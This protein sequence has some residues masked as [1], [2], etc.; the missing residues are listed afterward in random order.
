MSKFQGL[1][2]Y[3]S[4][5][6]AYELLPFRFERL[7]GGE[8]VLTN[9]VGEFA[10]LPQE[11][12]QALVDHQLPPTDSDYAMLRMK[13]ILREPGDEAT[14][15]LLA[16]KTRTRLSHL[17]N[18]TNLHLFVVS[19]RCDHSCQYCQVSRQSEDKAAFD[20]TRE[21]ADKS[22][23]I[24]FRS[25]N[26]AIKIEFQGGEPL[27]NFPLIQYVVEKAEQRNVA[28]Q[29]NLQFVITTTLS[30]ATDDILGY[31]RDHSIIL[32]SS[33]DGPE[34]LHNKN[35][36]RP[37]RDS[38]ARFVDGLN[39]A[40]DIVGYDAVS[41][42][43]T[44]S[45]ASIARVKDIIDEY[46]RLGF[47]GIFLRH[48]SPYGFA[49]K[50][51]SYQAYNTEQWLKF[52][53]EGLDYIIELNKAGIP[54]I[55][56]YSNILLTKML[57]STDPGFVDL[58]NP[59]GAGITAVVFNYDGEVYASDESRMLKEMGDA[60]FRLGNVHENSYEE[61]FTAEGLLTALEESFTLSVPM[62]TDC[63]F[64]PWCGADPVFHHGMYGDM[65]GRKPESE[66]CKRTTGVAKY[67]L[68]IM[69]KDQEAKELFMRWVNPC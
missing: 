18:F 68:E 4:T 13:H 30:L 12:L 69:K 10:F 44:T 25:P 54:F 66:F 16:L 52:F 58:S 27:L 33:L 59:S 42:L 67:L 35:R 19:L 2:A 8:V 23:D 51:K 15:E 65:L 31:C 3:I 49:L 9:A 22:L 28:E 41:A 21:T 48:L 5:T 61:I 37:G 62:C 20:M 63:A 38:Y 32:S 34:D 29:R 24:V 39:R 64:E 11:K 26:Q 60:S 43:M 40:R 14:L 46:V 1:D 45:P 57:T 47:N 50:T 56:H 55:E 53:K 36:P 17:A 7:E 6:G